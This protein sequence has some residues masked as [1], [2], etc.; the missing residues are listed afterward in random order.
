MCG[1]Q[2]EKVLINVC[3][4]L[5]MVSEMVQNTQ[6]PYSFTFNDF[7]LVHECIHSHSTTTL[8]F[9]V[10]TIHIQRH[11]FYLRIYSFTFATYIHSHSRSQFLFHT[12][13]AFNILLISKIHTGSTSLH[14]ERFNFF[15][16]ISSFTFA[17]NIHPHS[18]TIFF[19]QH[20][21]NINSTFCAHPLL[22]I[23]GSQIPASGNTSFPCH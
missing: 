15:S 22:R 8:S 9:N 16:R 7:I 21:C 5:C 2:R 23:I 6:I 18:T 3:I 12:W 17:I 19:I 1:K 11:I 14:I 13:F 4:L 10:D 20:C